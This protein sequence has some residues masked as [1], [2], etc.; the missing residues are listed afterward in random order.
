[1]Q[2]IAT[3]WPLEITMFEVRIDDRQLKKLERTVRSLGGNIGTV[4]TRALNRAASSAKTAAGRLLAAE[5]GIAVRQISRRLI[6]RKATRR[7]WRSSVIIP[8]RRLPLSTLKPRRVRRGLSV[9]AGRKRVIIQSGFEA[10]DGWFI[11][12]PAAGAARGVIE[13]PQAYDWQQDQLVGR[14]PVAQI[15]GPI[16]AQVWSDARA[17]ANTI[18]RRSRQ[19]LEKSVADQVKLILQRGA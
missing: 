12:R 18:Y 8:R 1:M 4:M 15:K 14:L 11:R 10:M 6:L 7:T 16:L 2:A 3:F 17:E 9:Q 5:T 19:T 13:P